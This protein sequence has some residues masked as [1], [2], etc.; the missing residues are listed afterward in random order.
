MIYVA[1]GSNLNQ[2]AERL[3]ET[4]GR[5]RGTGL[6]LR[7]LSNYWRTAPWG[8][9]PQPDFVNA[10]CE[11]ETDLQPEELLRLLLTVETDMGRERHERWGPRVIDLDLLTYGQGRVET[12]ELTLPHPRLSERAFVL[13]PWAE[14]AP[15]FRP[16]PD[17]PPVAEMAAALPPKDRLGCEKIS[18][19]DLWQTIAAR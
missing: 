9:T 2:P 17:G 5:M 12:P 7:Q 13:L 3:T 18:R 16:L 11:I 10:V 4:L 15:D 6:A 19:C 1:L 8:P 14:I